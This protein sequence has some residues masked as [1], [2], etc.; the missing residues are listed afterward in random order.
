MKLSIIYPICSFPEP[1]NKDAYPHPFLLT[2][3]ASIL[4][5]R[6]ENFELLVGID[7]IRPKVK[8]FVNYWGVQHNLSRDQLKIFEFEFTG[9]YG[10]HQRNEL[11]ERATGNYISFMDHD[12]EYTSTAFETIQNVSLKHPG[13][14]QFFR[15]LVYQNK[16]TSFAQGKPFKLWRDNAAGVLKQAHVGGHMFVV[17]NRKE[18]LGR[19]TLD[20][21][22]ADFDFI[23]QTIGNYSR[24]GVSAVWVDH[25]IAN[26]R[27]WGFNKEV[28]AFDGQSAYK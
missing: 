23:D 16:V 28:G 24:A 18:F 6:F 1:L 11:L 19:W 17:P 9:T 22:E 4:N 7:G 15:M 27:P 10:N 12:D 13:Q 3:L 8:E 20:R 25:V 21:Y 14:P 2:S 5:N 26:V